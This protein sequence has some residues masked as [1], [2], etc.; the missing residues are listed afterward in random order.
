LHQKLSIL[1]K[2]QALQVFGMFAPAIAA[3]HSSIVDLR[4]EASHLLTKV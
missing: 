2:V 4:K 1:R 3:W